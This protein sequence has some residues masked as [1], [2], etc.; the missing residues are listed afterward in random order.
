MQTW[1]QKWAGN[2]HNPDDFVRFVDDVGCC[3]WHELP[4]FSDFPCQ[5]DA[6]GRLDPGAGD[7]WFWKD[8]LHAEKRVYYTWLFGGQPG[9]ISFGMLPAF[10]ATNGMTID[11]VQYD[12]LLT[13]ETQQVYRA[14]EE[15]G[16]VPIRELKDMLGP[17]AKR[18]CTR[19][20]HELDRWFIATKTG[21]SGRTRHT[22]GYIWDLVER[23]IPDVLTAADGLGRKN[24]EAAVR[25]RLAGFGIG[26]DSPFC[27]KVLGW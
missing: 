23:W 1:R 2:V 25:E 21:I 8:D 11:E 18:A 26:E 15:Y 9:F 5:D 16:P 22:Y 3:T 19:V 20:L 6:M 10:I 13:P 7:T 4:G 24:A 12:G 14:I 17:D 27:E